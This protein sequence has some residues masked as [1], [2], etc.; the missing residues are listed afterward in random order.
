MSR[1]NSFTNVIDSWF[2]KI[3]KENLIG[4]TGIVKYCDDMVFVFEME[5]DV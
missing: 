4:Q 3:S 5:A 2:A 1:L